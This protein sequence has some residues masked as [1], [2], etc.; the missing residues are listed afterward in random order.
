[1]ATFG[2]FLKA[3]RNKKGLNQS[4][5]GQQVGGIIMTD[6]SKIENGHKKFPFNKLKFLA[7]F[8]NMDFS[9]LKNIYVGDIIVEVAQ[10]YKCTNA[11]YSVA[12]NQSKYINHKNTKQGVIKF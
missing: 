10:K 8:L 7:K 4:D 9:D 5:F 11:V 6:I 12:E 1:M 2:M 3:E